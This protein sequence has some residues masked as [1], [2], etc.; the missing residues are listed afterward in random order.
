MNQ[1]DRI[2]IMELISKNSYYYDFNQP[3]KR[4]TIFTD[5]LHG[6][7]WRNGKQIGKLDTLNK[8]LELQNNRRASLAEQGIQPRH[9]NTDIM[10]DEVSEG[11]VIGSVMFF[12]THQKRDENKPE[13]VHTGVYDFEFRKIDKEWKISKRISYTD[14]T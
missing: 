4:R 5:D 3:E 14:H 6:E 12:T 7:I 2:Q 13:V 11:E 8:F 10:L 9:F 1:E